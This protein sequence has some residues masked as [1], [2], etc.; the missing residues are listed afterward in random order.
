MTQDGD[1]LCK[2]RIYAKE[3]GISNP[4]GDMCLG[5]P[6]DVNVHAVQCKQSSLSVLFAH[7][8]I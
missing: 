5:E 3:Y 8:A 2:F 4:G 1:H 7:R 6:D